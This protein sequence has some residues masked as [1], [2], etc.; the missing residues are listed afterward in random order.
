MTH[1]GEVDPPEI[2]HLAPLG[3]L[4]AEEARYRRLGQHEKADAFKAAIERLRRF[5]ELLDAL[6]RC[7]PYLE[8]ARDDPSYKPGGVQVFINTVRNV[9]RVWL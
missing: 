1:T 9:L 3:L 2:Y 6:V 7:V 8:C 4:V 5:D